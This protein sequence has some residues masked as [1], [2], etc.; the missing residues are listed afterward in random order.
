M[1]KTSVFLIAILA[2]SILTAVPV[3]S[4]EAPWLDGWS[5]RE[6]FYYSS[7]TATTDYQGSLT[8]INDTG[9]NADN[10]FYMYNETLAAFDDIRVTKNDGTTLLPIWNQTTHY[11]LNC[12]FWVKFPVVNASYFLYWNNLDASNVWNSSTVFI[13]VIGGVVGA[14]NMEEANALNNV[15]DYSGNNFTGTPTGTTVV[16]GKFTGK[17]ARHIN[18]LGDII[19]VNHNATLSLAATDFTITAWVKYSVGDWSILWKGESTY[20]A[21]GTGYEFHIESG[22]KK[23]RFGINN[24]V[25]AAVSTYSADISALWGNYLFIVITADRDG[26]AQIYV[27]N[28]ASGAA[29]NIAAKADISNAANL[30]IGKYGATNDEHFECSGINLFNSLLSE[31]QRANLY[32]NY[33]DVTLEYGKVL[34]RNYVYPTPSISLFGSVE[35]VPDTQ[36]YAT[37]GYVT[38]IIFLGIFIIAPMAL[39]FFT[40]IK[41]RR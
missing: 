21:A 9:F 10:T 25:G 27:N 15:A 1:K 39:I 31:A 20:A 19:T 36:I 26:N 14:W 16:A 17:N 11:S 13:D 22:I 3:I 33:G 4:A 32:N 12:T 18:G 41:R 38:G 40:F 24:G 5:K 30:L 6:L 35:S 7:S 34:V 8:V 2:L 37:P 23:V 29:V 28:V